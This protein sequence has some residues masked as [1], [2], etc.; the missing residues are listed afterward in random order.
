MAFRTTNQ[1]TLDAIAAEL[2]EDGED[3]TRVNVGEEAGIDEAVR[4]TKFGHN[5]EFY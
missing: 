1:D 2:K 4:V 5:Y 3:V